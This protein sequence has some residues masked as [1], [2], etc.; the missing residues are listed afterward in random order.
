MIHKIG[1]A[2]VAAFLTL[3]PLTSGAQDVPSGK[4]LLNV[5]TTPV[6][7]QVFVNG[8]K[9]ADQ[10]PTKLTLPAGTHTVKLRPV[11]SDWLEA[12]RVVSLPN[13]SIRTLNV[14]LL[15]KLT[16]GP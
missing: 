5:A 9:L 8:V 13:Q 11:S 14:T 3:A 2:A 7:V 10:T 15:P 6:Q 4:G 1:T 12:T 16:V